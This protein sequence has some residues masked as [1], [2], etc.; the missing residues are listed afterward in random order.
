[1][2]ATFIEKQMLDVGQMTIKSADKNK[3][4]GKQPIQL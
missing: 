2:R 1:M 3:I 4:T